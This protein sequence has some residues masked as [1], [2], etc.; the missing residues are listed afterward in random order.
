[1]M[2]NLVNIPVRLKTGGINV[3]A[4]Q[5]MIKYDT[6]L[7]EFKSVKNELKSSLWL[8]YINT[9]ENKVEWVDMTQQTMLTY[10]T[11]VS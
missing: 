3:G 5:L 4:L 10:S 11:M 7:L 8:S 2:V 6:S 1:M 9:S